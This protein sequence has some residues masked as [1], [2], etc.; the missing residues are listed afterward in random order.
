VHSKCTF[1]ELAF[2][3]FS[4]LRTRLVFKRSQVRS[5]HSTP[6]KKFV[7]RVSYLDSGFLCCGS[8][9]LDGKRVRLLLIQSVLTQN[10]LYNNNLTMAKQPTPETPCTSNRPIL[11]QLSVSNITLGMQVVLYDNRRKSVTN[12]TG[13]ILLFTEFISL[14]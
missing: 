3:P 12:T 10:P 2:L 13:T 11:R 5:Q 1:R 14:Q 4:G 6:N 9:R 8:A 7:N